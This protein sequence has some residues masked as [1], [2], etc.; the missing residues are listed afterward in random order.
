MEALL[1]QRGFQT[2][3]RVFGDLVPD[4]HAVRQEACFHLEPLEFGKQ[5]AGLIGLARTDRT[6]ADFPVLARARLGSQ[7]RA[8]SAPGVPQQAC[9]LGTHLPGMGH[10]FFWMICQALSRFIAWLN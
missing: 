3:E 6:E 4:R 7:G 1:D 9:P 10:Y 5:R 2:L 8:P